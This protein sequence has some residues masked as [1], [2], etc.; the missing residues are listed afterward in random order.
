MDWNSHAPC[1]YALIGACFTILGL[2]GLFVLQMVANRRQHDEHLAQLRQQEDLIVAV[3]R[4]LRNEDYER[5]SVITDRTTSLAEKNATLF[6][7]FTQVLR[8]GAY[9]QKDVQRLLSEI[10]LR[11]RSMEEGDKS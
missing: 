11:L 2:A 5:F 3:M 8:L 7:K 6:S 10:V 1:V 4:E 9:A